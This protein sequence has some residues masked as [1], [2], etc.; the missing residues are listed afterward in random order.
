MA[1]AI[2]SPVI[3]GALFFV[4]QMQPGYAANGQVW[5]CAV[6]NAGNF[7]APPSPVDTHVN[8]AILSPGN[9]RH[10]GAGGHGLDLGIMA[11]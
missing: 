10:V 3:N 11:V 6:I 8:A 2:R 4:D 7:K 9:G 5:V 1:A